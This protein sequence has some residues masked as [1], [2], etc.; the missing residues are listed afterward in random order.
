MVGNIREAN[1]R[2]T[3]KS[4]SQAKTIRCWAIFNC[5]LSTRW[6]LPGCMFSLMHEC[7]HYISTPS[8]CTRIDMSSSEQTNQVEIIYV[9]NIQKS[10]ESKKTNQ[11][12]PQPMVYLPSK[13]IRTKIISTWFV[14]S[15]E[16]RSIRVQKKEICMKLGS[17][18]SDLLR[19]GE[20]WWGVGGSL[21]P[22][23]TNG[24][25][26]PCFAIPPVSEFVIRTFGPFVKKG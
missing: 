7:H 11:P 17:S 4:G 21:P 19:G 8:L 5:L 23:K 16:D 13:G 20:R 25:P 6:P 15:L 3:N 22:S 14:C 1:P 10:K 18:G 26:H 24:I 9:H 12:T 2:E